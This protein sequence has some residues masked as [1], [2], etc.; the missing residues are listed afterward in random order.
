MPDA[1]GSRDTNQEG[2]FF[3]T[4]A[5]QEAADRENIPDMNGGVLRK[6]ETARQLRANRDY[7]SL[8]PDGEEPNA[9]Q[10]S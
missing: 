1:S 3:L 7:G 8:G 2:S 5:E 10:D 6:P 4:P 9:R